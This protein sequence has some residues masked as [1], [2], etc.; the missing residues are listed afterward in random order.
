M[1]DYD[2]LEPVDLLVSKAEVESEKPLQIKFSKGTPDLVFECPICFE[3][4]RSLPF[5]LYPC[6][7]SIC[8]TCRQKLLTDSR[9]SNCPTW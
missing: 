2:D 3:S 9:L 7:H 4:Q 5:V 1:E 6:G 8:G